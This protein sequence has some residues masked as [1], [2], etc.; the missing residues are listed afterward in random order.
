MKEFFIFSKNMNNIDIKTLGEKWQKR[1]KEAKVFQS[2]ED[3]GKKKFYIL[4][5]FPY[6]SGA[7]LHVGHP[8]G[9]IASDSIAR[10]KILEGYSVLHPMG[11]D[12]FGLWTENYAIKNK[13]LPQDAAA[14]NIARF[15]EQLDMFGT[16]YH[17]SREISTADPSMYKWTQWT[18]LQMYDHY[19]DEEEQKAR[20]ISELKLKME[21]WELKMK[22]WVDLDE[23]INSQRLAY[24]DYQPI[25]WCP[26]CQTGLANEDLDNG[27]CERCNSEVEQKMMKQWV[28]R[29]TK[30]AKRLLKWLEEL[31]GWDNS[32][33]DM[34]KNW[35]GKKEWIDIVYP[36]KNTEEEIVCFTTRPDTNFGA[37]FIV[38]APEHDFVK[39]II[40][41]E[42]HVDKE[43]YDK[44][45]E[46]IEQT[47]H[48]TELDRISEWKKKTWVFTWYYANHR[49]T[50]KKIPIWVSDFVLWNFGTWAVVWVPW[51]DIRDFEF[52]Q[53]FD[54]PILRVVVW[55]D[56][57]RSEIT[58]AKQ[59]QEEK[60]IIINSDFLDEMSIHDATKKIMS[61][62]VDKWRAE[63]V[64]NYRLKDRVFSRQRYRG[65]PIPMVHCE[66]C[67]VVPLDES[68]LPLT[69]PIVENYEPTGTEEWPLANID[70]WV[71]VDCPR[72]WGKW[73]RET[74]T[75][76]G[77][78]GS[79][80]YWLRYMD[81][82][83]EDALVNPKK[84]KYRWGVD[85][86]IGGAEHITRHMIYARFWNKF[87]YDIGIVSVSEPF[88][89]Y[90]KVGLI[91]AEDWRKMSKRRWNTIDPADIIK[92]YGSDVFRVYEMFMWPFDQAVAWSTNGVNW[93]KKF[94]D[95]VAKLFEKVEKDCEVDNKFT[96]LLHKTIK[97]VGED[98]D[99]F[100]FNTAISQMMIF[101]NE[102]TQ[103][104]KIPQEL[105]ENFVVIL[106]PFAP[107][108][109]EELWEMMWH[110][111]M[112]YNNVS[113]PE[114]E[115][116]LIV[117]DVI[118]LAVQFNGKMR[119]T[120]KVYKDVSQ[121]EVFKTIKNDEKLKKYLTGEPKKIIFVPGKIMNVIV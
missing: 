104:D 65:E 91:M 73:K 53:T 100:K 79:S 11:F 98:I 50:G 16:T 60:W 78:A 48:K 101:V 88:T 8:K 112:I 1:W 93:A 27:K 84:E 72:C 77:W 105:F 57:D 7:G 12:T 86:Y 42:I 15:K 25:N 3:L 99:G 23:F 115:E 90:Q 87:L 49:L 55:S 117:E 38:V 51:H 62:Y 4:D 29:I 33:K 2:V 34:Q 28:I 32:T 97:K 6:P 21:S 10:K 20:P 113:W 119:G 9:Y 40:D 24:M 121:D 19:F 68:E 81:P 63:K 66:K 5:M 111:E 14:Q 120:V 103:V 41:N 58:E 30:Y 69:L 75:M 61:Y 43:V 54:L 45:L 39:K 31:D 47:N 109:A 44:I 95:K 22:E 92:E 70:E 46:Y 83:N 102:L 110:E 64:I 26:N 67:G 116:N 35:I 18:F 94:L 114:Y 59:V 76:P 118:N 13:M 108:L 37:T 74:N 96:S 56:W 106:S 80:R 71:N 17:W 107:H 82:K 36:V 52:A 85:Q 89:R